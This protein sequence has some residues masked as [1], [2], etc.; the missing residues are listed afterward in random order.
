METRDHVAI[1]RGYA[2]DVVAGRIPACQSIRQQAKR[3]LD[4]LKV[5][6][7]AAFP[8][9]FDAKKAAKVCKFIELLPHSKGQWARKK[10]T[11]RLEPWQVWIICCTFGWLHKAGER[12]GRRRYRVLFVVVPR[13]NGKSALSAG[14]ALY[15]LCADGEYGAEVYLGATNE[16]QAGEVFVPAKIMAGKTAGLLEHYGVEILAHSLVRAEDN[17]KLEKIVG[18]PG[19][20]SS[21]SCSIHDEYHEH[22]DDGQV[23]TMRT[24]MGARDQPLQVLIT[25]AGYNLAGPCYASIQE[26][27]KKLAGVG[28]LEPAKA[29]RAACGLGADGPDLQDVTFFVEYTTDEGDDWKSEAVLRKANPNF[30]ISVQADFLLAEQRDAI[31]RPRRQGIFKTKHLDVWVAAKEAYYDIEAWRRCHDPAMP[32]RPS[33][34]LAQFAGRRAIASLDLA[35]KWDIAALELLILPIGERATVD[36]P[37]IRIGWYFLPADVVE[38]VPH[39]LAWHTA[40]LIEATPGNI[41]DYDEIHEALRTIRGTVQLE[42]VGYD[43]HQA[44]MFATT[45][46]KEGFP[47]IEVPQTVLVLSEPMKE[48]DALMRARLM[49]HGGDA[50]MEWQV[51][52]VTG[53]PDKKDNVYPNK[54][55]ADAKID[56]P[57]ALMGAL[58]LALDREGEGDMAS[59]FDD[60]DFQLAVA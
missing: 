39:Y 6:K 40:G 57:V 18:Q 21:P 23:E 33:E 49:R 42:A 20:G 50:V 17:S 41:T 59:P 4:E 38:D 9:R 46:L 36:D 15:M 11:I 7:R 12:K 3:F 29:A 30:G 52:N 35:S 13:K 60:P 5:E 19:D 10:E 27:R 47:M 48:L 25:T 14:I 24:G 28:L 2:R 45:L 26:E 54:P 37:Y 44:T 53:A 16:K 58:R 34:A 55:R 51:A 43:Q 56:N 32:V 22:K 1:A 8:Y 31:A